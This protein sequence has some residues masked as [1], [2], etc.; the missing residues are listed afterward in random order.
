MRFNPSLGLYVWPGPIDQN[1]RHN[2][3]GKRRREAGLCKIDHLSPEPVIWLLRVFDGFWSL[4]RLSN[5]EQRSSHKLCQTL[6]VS[7][8]ARKLLDGHTVAG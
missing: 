8:S 1:C 6:E 7:G 2:S 4:Q 5:S 3:K